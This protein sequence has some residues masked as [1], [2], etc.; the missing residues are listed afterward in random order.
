MKV[1]FEITKDEVKQILL[2]KIKERFP[3]GIVEMDTQMPS[4]SSDFARVEV[5]F[6][7]FQKQKEKV[8]KQGCILSVPCCEHSYTLTAALPFGFS[9]KCVCHE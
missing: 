5:E 2:D 9:C 3:D 7:I 4:Y 1:K 6:E 8:A